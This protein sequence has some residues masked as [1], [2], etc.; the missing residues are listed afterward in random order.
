LGYCGVEVTD[1]R[2]VFEMEFCLEMVVQI[3]VIVVELCDVTLVSRTIG[4]LL[5]CFVLVVA[6]EDLYLPRYVM[7]GGLARY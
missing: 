5:F 2:P 4:V 3:A 7:V 1:E 6:V